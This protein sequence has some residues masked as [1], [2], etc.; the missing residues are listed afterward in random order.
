MAANVVR[1][2]RGK[3][4]NDVFNTPGLVDALTTGFANAVKEDV[5][6]GGLVYDKDGALSFKGPKKG[7]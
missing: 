3:T 4:I 6:Y 2:V 1:T 7:Q 5:E